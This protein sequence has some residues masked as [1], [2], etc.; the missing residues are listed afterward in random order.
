VAEVSAELAMGAVKEFTVINYRS[1]AP[2][3]CGA[4]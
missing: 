3:I 1:G 4:V 2:I